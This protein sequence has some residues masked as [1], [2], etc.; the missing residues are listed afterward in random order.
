MG[1]RRNTKEDKRSRWLTKKGMGEK[2]EKN[3][4]FA[5]RRPWPTVYVNAAD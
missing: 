2:K 3:E 4:R 5:D 1:R